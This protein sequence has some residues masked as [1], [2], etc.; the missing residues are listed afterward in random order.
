MFFNTKNT[1]GK[2]E[3]DDSPAFRL[4]GLQKCMK[5]QILLHLAVVQRDDTLPKFSME[6]KKDGFQKESPIQGCHF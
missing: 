4:K 6:T 5:L 2:I 1:T 3:T